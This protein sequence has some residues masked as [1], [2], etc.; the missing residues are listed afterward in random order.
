LAA[1]LSS[2][3]DSPAPSDPV[4][5]ELLLRELLLARAQLHSSDDYA[6][7]VEKYRSGARLSVH[8]LVC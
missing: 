8:L 7:L 5:V 6:D 3:L 4:V 2:M 1:T